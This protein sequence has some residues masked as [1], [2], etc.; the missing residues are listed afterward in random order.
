MKN[1]F[2]GND[3]VSVEKLLKEDI[4]LLFDHA[5]QMKVIVDGH[6]SLDVLRGKVMAALFYEPSS[7]TF[8]SFLSAMQRLG[9]GIIPLNGMTNTSVAKGETFEDTVQ[10]FSAYADVLVIRHPDVGAL[11]T[12]A[13][14]AS[15][16]VINAGEGAFGEHPTQACIDLFTIQEHFGKVDGL[17]ILIIGDLAHYRPTNSLMKLLAN[18]PGVQLSVATPPE[19]SMQSELKD[20]LKNM[21]VNFH[22]YIDFTDVLPEADVLYVTRVKKEYMP[23]D[24][25]QKIRGSYVVDM[26]VAEKMKKNSIIMHCLPRIDE[27]ATDVDDN[28]RSLYFSKQLQ[29]GL[30]VRMALLSL[31][32][33]KTLSSKL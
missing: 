21:K 20:F 32:L 16:P 24:L 6:K 8:G 9:G 23:E 25:Y 30:Y 22:E 4:D 31:L 19:V 12:A 11:V 17:H 7:R 2:F 5:R 33:N 14:F 26:A 3:I 15:V 29:N 27:I 1:N 28:P 18:Y 13:K 10:T